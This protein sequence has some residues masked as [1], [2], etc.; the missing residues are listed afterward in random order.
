M[1][2]FKEYIKI[3]KKALRKVRKFL[4]TCTSN[5][6]K[7]LKSK[8]LTIFPRR[9]SRYFDADKHEIK[10]IGL[11]LGASILVNLFIE[12]FAR[13][14][15]NPVDGIIFM[16][17]HPLIFGFNTLI[18]FATMTI[19]LLF[20]RRRFAWIIISLI[21]VILGMVNGMI[22]LKRMTPFTLYD[23]QNLEDGAT[24]L[25][26]YFQA[27]QIIVGIIAIMILVSILILV[28]IRSKKWTNI[29]YKKSITAILLSFGIAITTGIVFIGS[30]IISTFF[31][32]LNYAYRDNGF[33]Y[34]FIVT[35][36][37]AGIQKPAGY[38]E[39]MIFSILNE[40]TSNGS[41]REGLDEKNE[42]EHPNIL[43][44]QMESFTTSQDYKNLSVDRDPTPVFNSLYEDFSSGWFAV[45]A[46]GAGTANTEFEVLTG[47]SAKF[48]GPGEYPY[49]GKLRKQ[50]LES[51]A[52]ICKGHGYT[53]SALHNHRALFYNRNEVYANMGFDSFTSV[54]YMNNII[55]TPTGW[56]KDKIMIDNILQIMRESKT[57]DFMHIVS[58][59]GHGSY[60]TEQVFTAP[61]TNVQMDDLASKWKYEYYLNECH[62]M[63]N[64]I[65]ELLGEIQEMDEP[66]IVLIY[67]DHIPALEV[68]EE[69]YNG[70]DLYHTKYVIWDNIGL[71]AK[72]Q[73]INAY[74][75]GALLL[76]EADYKNEGVLF[77][78]QENA[79][80]NSQNYLT[81][82]EA[83]S[84][85]ILYGS[86]YSYGGQNPYKRSNM[87]MGYSPI[88]IKDI[89]KIGDNYYIRGN[90]FTEHSSISHK[91]KLLK[92]IYLSSTLLALRD[93]IDPDTVQELEI[94]QIDTKDNTILSTIGALEEL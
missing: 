67:G 41:D 64:F 88:S 9:E 48:F 7:Y 79:D 36:F 50:T 89:I 37:S 40:N 35:S 93:D 56:C 13:L 47:I 30:G 33:P 60:P 42:S 55:K 86:Y 68:K 65:G 76:S 14:T 63:D 15:N 46:C 12:T 32:N 61:Y 34:C 80:R 78:Y 6:A 82:L 73:N 91:G 11:M 83:L 75:I 19:A 87:S 58:V 77:D 54:E 59:E 85:D 92:T 57:R 71:K 70:P 17:S 38:S 18:I 72:H 4:F 62:E 21:W 90:N 27:W 2:D 81:N 51:L 31:G 52:Y 26:T 94:S 39:E 10:Y 24:L 1:S 43:I 22:L 74:E 25:T 69:N 20:K 66:T 84:Y 8:F 16:F 29:K 53:T 23:L 28:F 3:I 45:P 44:L 5:V 49:K